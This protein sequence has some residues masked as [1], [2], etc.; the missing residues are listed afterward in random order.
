MNH[1]CLEHKKIF[2]FNCIESDKNYCLQCMEEKK[3]C[4]EKSH[5]HNGY[6]KYLTELAS[7]KEKKWLY[8]QELSKNLEER[9]LG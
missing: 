4:R 2:N 1:L 3:E 8:I 7:L 9:K 6:K 5:N